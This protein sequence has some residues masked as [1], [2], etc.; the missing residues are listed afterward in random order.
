MKQWCNGKVH[1]IR[2]HV[3]HLMRGEI[4]NINGYTFFAMGGATSQDKPL[5][6]VGRNWWA[7]EI[8][9]F[10]EMQNGITNLEKYNNKVDY[11]LS[12]TI[13]SS[14]L[15][16]ALRH[17]EEDALTKY[18]DLIKN[19]NYKQWFSGHYHM[20]RDIS[21]NITL[22]YNHIIEIKKEG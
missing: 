4:Y 7:E 18:F 6:T 9:S 5:R 1:V 3:Y 11:I 10:L 12:H 19:V 14:N 16:E 17:S 21:N 2:P 20:D 13:P 8:P 22:V 15:N